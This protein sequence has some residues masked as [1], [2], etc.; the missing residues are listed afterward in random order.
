VSELSEV[1]S[2]RSRI[3]CENERFRDVSDIHGERW[4]SNICVLSVFVLNES[5]H[6]GAHEI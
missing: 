3:P 2:K 4:E 6:G 1:V 5:K